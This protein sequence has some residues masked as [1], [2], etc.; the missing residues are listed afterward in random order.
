MAK[1]KPRPSE[2]VF[3]R[4]EVAQILNCSPLT[5]RNREKAGKYPPPK[6]DLNNYRLYTLADVL[7]LQELTFDAVNP[8]VI[9]SKLYDKGYKNP[10]E[11]GQLMDAALARR[12]GSYSRG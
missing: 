6:R 11:I 1:A 12:T 2:P 7:A 4:G 10:K 3:T 5:M 8:S 9:V